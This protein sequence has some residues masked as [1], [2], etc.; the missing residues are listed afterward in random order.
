MFC[1]F[2]LQL[3]MEKRRHLFSALGPETEGKNKLLKN[4][5][6]FDLQLSK[7]DSGAHIQWP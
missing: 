1:N 6:R 4:E 2:L 3:N 7:G 5:I